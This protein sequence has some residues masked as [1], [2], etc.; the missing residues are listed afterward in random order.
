MPAVFVTGSGT[1]VGKTFVTAG[2]IRYLREQGHRVSA[3]KPVVSGFNPAAPEESDPALLLEALGRQ[4]IEAEWERISPWRFTAPLSPDM[5]ARVEN[6]R[7]DF[8]ALTSFCQDSIRESGDGFLLIEGIGGIMV[9]LDERHAVLDLIARL[10]IPIILV[11]GS[12]LGTLSHL[13]S[14]QDVVLSR[15]LDLRALVISE[16]EG[17]TV[18]FEETLVSLDHFAGAPVLGLRREA[19]PHKVFFERLAR[20]I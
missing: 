14:A 3:L 7:L 18:P 12:Y 19:Q 15:E 1:G 8:E 9:P 11:G 20:L 4:S 16:S 17:A 5:A 13:L 2:L 6:R 10:N